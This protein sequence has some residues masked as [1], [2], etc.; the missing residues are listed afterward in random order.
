MDRCSKGGKGLDLEG[1]KVLV[2]GMART[3]LAAARFLLE[4]K[5]R[6]VCTDV[7]RLEEFGEEVRILRDRGCRLSLGGHRGEE[8][9]GADLIV[10]S[11]GVPPTLPPLEEAQAAGVEIIGEVE[12]AFRY[13][14]CPIIAV[15]GTNG[16]T[17]TVHLID[18]MLEEAGIPHWVGGNIGRP[19]TEFLLCPSGGEADR[20]PEVVV[21]EVSSFQLETTVHFRP[22]VAL[23]TNLSP[24]HLD[25][26]PNVEAYAEAKARIFRKQTPRDYAVVP[27][28]D[29]WLGSREDRIRARR[30]RFGYPA[31]PEPEVCL[32][33][34]RIVFRQGRAC[35][36]E[37][38]RTDRVRVPGRHNLENMMS[39]LAAARLFGADPDAVQRAMDSFA[40]LEH[41]VEYVAESRGVRF[42]NDS[43]ATTV[44]SVIRAL[45]CF[46]TPVLLLA[47]GKDKG[48]PFAPLQASLKRHVRRLF[49]YGE[50][51]QRMGR[52]LEGAA[53]IEY[54]RD[55]EEATDRAWRAARAG[56]IILLSPACSSFDRYRDYEE[57]G[58]DFKFLVKR[59]RRTGAS[60]ER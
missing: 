54:A 41:R 55:L 58:R 53:E 16:K 43:K 15:T 33:E 10:V 12:L 56:E 60:T 19:L 40:G 44:D 9:L 7:R 25:R 13:M 47:G 31:A 59:I 48:F 8:F 32:R 51:A 21:A 45:E 3:G 17:T 2:V 22:R 52:E 20:R 23:W 30:I 1:R 57:R 24:D 49:L 50:A 37:S 36:A 34:G 14:T 35:E 46:E 4:Q 6:V 26:Y 27:D 29:P 38:Y 39:A 11:P 5:A 18:T 28:K 42:Y